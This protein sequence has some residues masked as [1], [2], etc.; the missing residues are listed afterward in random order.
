[1]PNWRATDAPVRAADMAAPRALPPGEP[2]AVHDG[3]PHGWAVDTLLE[4]DL[5]EVLAIEEA[6]FT[7]PWTRQM[8]LWELQNVGIS[9]GYVLR[10]PEWRVAAFC[11]I[12]VVLDEIHINNIAVRPECRGGGVGR[13]LLEF[14]LRLGAGLGARRA[15]LEVR[16]SNAAAL[17]LYERLGFSVAGV[18]K[19]YYANPVED[20]LILWRDSAG[21]RSGSVGGGGGGAT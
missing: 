3:L 8:F 15:T 14:V 16:R 12:W 21:D 11:T 13:A 5:D 6:S 17:K 2:A 18:R 19:N 20:A 9:Y 4:E 1:M 10:T 7:N